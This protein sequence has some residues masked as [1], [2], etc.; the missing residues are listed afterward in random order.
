MLGG[1]RWKH[2]WAQRK[3]AGD[4]SIRLAWLTGW[5]LQVKGGYIPIQDTSIPPLGG[6]TRTGTFQFPGEAFLGLLGGLAGLNNCDLTQA[7][8]V[9]GSGP[10]ATVWHHWNVSGFSLIFTLLSSETTQRVMVLESGPVSHFFCDQDIS[11]FQRPEYEPGIGF[12]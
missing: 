7:V 6:L 5:S 12:C 10:V 4:V 9:L 2:S 8:P 11:S 1:R 3:R